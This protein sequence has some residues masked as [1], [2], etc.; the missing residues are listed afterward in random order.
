M[1]HACS[2]PKRRLVPTGKIVEFPKPD[3][4]TTESDANDRVDKIKGKVRHA[5]EILESGNSVKAY[6][7]LKE[8]LEN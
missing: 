8:I 2:S 4:A 7:A 5:L 6:N 1:T 3:V